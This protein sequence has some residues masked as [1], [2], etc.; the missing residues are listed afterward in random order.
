MGAWNR[1]AERARRFGRR[2]GISVTRHAIGPELGRAS[3][4][5][6]AVSDRAIP[7]VGRLLAACP[8]L[9]PGAVVAHTSGALPGKALGRLRGASVASFHPLAAI[10][11]R[12][13][14]SLKSMTFAV[15][16]E[17][18]ARHYLSRTAAALGSPSFVIRQ[19]D[20]ARYH[21]ACSL[22]SNMVV[23]LVALAA[24]EARG[25]GVP[26]A[27]LRMLALSENALA[28][29]RTRGFVG[30]LTGPI[31]RG[32]LETVAAHL[33]ALGASTRPL[34]VRLAEHAVVLARA[35]GLTR[36]DAAAMG[37]ILTRASRR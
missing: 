37:T 19:H 36:C 32:D 15:E 7:A 1:G 3:L 2:F 30:G 33:A 31:V 14:I 27:D 20:K 24:R 8:S 11:A 35:A 29:A 4:V 34:Y 5:V 21:A 6:V 16:G 22:A 13:Q 25:A 26:D 12:G 10:P 28:A 18:R 9:H 17:A 23:A